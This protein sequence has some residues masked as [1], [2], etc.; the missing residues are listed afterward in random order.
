MEERAHREIAPLHV[1]LVRQAI[2]ASVFL[3]EPVLAKVHLARV[4]RL[5]RFHPRPLRAANQCAPLLLALVQLHQLGK[6]HFQARLVLDM[7]GKF[8]YSFQVLRLAVAVVVVPPP[9]I[10][11]PQDELLLFQ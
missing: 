9:L 3:A 5:G 10:G 1:A 7:R 8:G 4:A 6:K 2:I 11:A